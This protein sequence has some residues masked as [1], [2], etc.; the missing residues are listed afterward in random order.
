[1][2]CRLR[3]IWAA[4]CGGQFMKPQNFDKLVMNTVASYDF[5]HIAKLGDRYGVWSQRYPVILVND[6]N[7]A[8]D[9]AGHLAKVSLR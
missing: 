9:L 6:F 5:W 8:F 7:K 2:T 3:N 4:I 1:M